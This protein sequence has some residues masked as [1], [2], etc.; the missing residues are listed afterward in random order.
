VRTLKAILVV[1]LVLVLLGSTG[2]TYLGNRGRDALDIFDMGIVVSDHV[3][4]DFAAFMTFWNLFPMGYANVDGKLIGIGGGR[5]GVL[6]FRHVHS[7]GVLAWGAEQHAVGETA[8]DAEAPARYEEGFLRLA[9]DAENKPLPHTYYDCDRTF[10]LGWVGLHLR[11]KLDDLADFITG[12]VGMDIMRDDR[13][14]EAV[15]EQT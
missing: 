6:D 11:V 15:G 3:R 9:L 10:V 2:C 12:W 14:P 5:A 13:D 4:P 8:P 7:W 1:A